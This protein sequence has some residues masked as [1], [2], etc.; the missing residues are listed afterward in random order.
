MFELIFR[1]I[2]F[3]QIFS[4]G[5]FI[6]IAF[7]SVVTFKDPQLL[8]TLLLL[9]RLLFFVNEGRLLGTISK[10]SPYCKAFLLFYTYLLFESIIWGLFISFLIFYV[11]LMLLKIHSFYWLFKFVGLFFLT[12][13]SIFSKLF[14]ILTGLLVDSN[15]LLILL[16]IFVSAKSISFSFFFLKFFGFSLEIISEIGLFSD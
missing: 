3:V 2:K 14:I 4:S 11:L 8:Y 1:L 13:K 10:F 15:L 7:E 9:L 5:S 16:R 12:R 6:N